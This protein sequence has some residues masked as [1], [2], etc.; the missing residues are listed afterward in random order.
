ME[1][2]DASDGV[3][4]ILPPE[5]INP[6]FP[7]NNVA[8][9]LGCDARFFPHAMTTVASLLEHAGPDNN[10]DLFVVQDGIAP[11]RLAQA[12]SWVKRFPNA[13]LRFVDI[14]PLVEKEGKNAFRTPRKMSYATFFRIFA[15]ELFSGIDKILYLD[16]DL[17]VFSD[18][19]P[20]YNES[21]GDNLL[22]GCHDFVAEEHSRVNGELGDFWLRQLHMEPGQ[23]YFNA[24]CVVMNLAGMRAGGIMRAFLDRNREITEG[25]LADQDV[26][27]SVLSGRVKYLDCAWNYFDWWYDPE[28]RSRNFS[29]MNERDRATVGEARSRVKI[30]HYAEKKPWTRDYTGYNARLYWHYARKMPFY[31]ESWANLKAECALW[32]TVKRKLVVSLQELNFNFR[33]RFSGP[34]GKTRYEARLYNLAMRKSGLDRQRALIREL[35]KNPQP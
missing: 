20:L 1:N 28:E 34:G 21:L 14:R 33:S 24:G 22:A 6:A 27:N 29:L 12:Q 3:K 4:V 8:V 10:Y 31:Q 19:A 26:M 5:P 11:E 30:L 35:E 25:N 17:V 2:S 32:P 16:S 9:F 15:S 7:R 18:V 23:P 13:S